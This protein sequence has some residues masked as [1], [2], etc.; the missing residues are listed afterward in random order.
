MITAMSSQPNESELEDELLALARSE[1]SASLAQAR[2]AAIRAVLR[3]RQRAR[4]AAERLEREEQ[5]RDRDRAKEK[6]DLE[7]AA[8]A[9]MLRTW[10]DPSLSDEKRLGWYRLDV[11]PLDATTEDL[12]KAAARWRRQAPSA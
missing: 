1:T 3:H 7:A 2:G 6:R 11:G 5:R 9:G 8:K 4:E 12:S 10:L